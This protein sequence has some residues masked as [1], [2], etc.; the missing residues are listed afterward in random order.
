[1]VRV[2]LAFFDLINISC[3]QRW[4]LKGILVQSSGALRADDLQCCDTWLKLVKDPGV[5][6]QKL[7]AASLSENLN[8]LHKISTGRREIGDNSFLRDFRARMLSSRSMLGSMILRDSCIGS[9]SKRKVLVSSGE[10][11]IRILI[12]VGK[13]NTTGSHVTDKKARAQTRSRPKIWQVKYE[14]YMMRCRLVVESEKMQQR[15]QT[16]QTKRKPNK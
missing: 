10:K 4:Q 16:Y 12:K 15:S 7:E 11:S 3:A 6:H 14:A 9:P 2:R 13:K 8:I 1:M 5:S